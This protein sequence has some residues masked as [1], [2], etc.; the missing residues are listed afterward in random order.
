MDVIL[1]LQGGGSLG[2]YECGVYQTLAPW[3]R[4][5]RHKLSVVC[6][7]SIGAMNASVIAAHHSDRDEGAGALYELW[8]SLKAGSAYFFPPFEDL[9][10]ANAVWTSL[11][12]G[13]PRMFRPTVPF[14]NFMPPVAW[15][16]FSAFYDTTP[17]QETLGRFFKT[18][19][20][21]RGDPRLILT[22]VDLRTE[23]VKVFDSYDTAITPRHV[24]ASCS[25]P[26]TFPA[27]ELNGT[28]YWDG[29][30]WSNTPIRD[31][32]NSIQENP[33]SPGPD[34]CADCLVFLVELFAP[35]KTD[36]GP[37]KGNWD[38]WARRDRII[39]QDK[40]EYDAKVAGVYNAHIDFVRKARRL[41]DAIPASQQLAVKQLAD[42][43][44]G[45]LGKLQQKR[46]LNLKIY[47]IPRYGNAADD[48]GREID[49]SSPR[50]DML[51]E[52][53]RSDS[54]SVINSINLA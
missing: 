21:G 42:H 11:L 13:N 41:L 51:I 8:Q 10:T 38:V 53:G 46:R 36:P 54:E 26:P 4:K 22:A 23:R 40:S 9:E 5:N 45:E 25:L 28:S 49:F 6:G 17:I 33:G 27:T 47:P 14:W 31:A 32:L 29:G 24:L 3:L 20:P 50:I 35:P 52:Q 12:L 39:F 15:A 34:A 7:T 30:L 44:N 1:V 18:L 48:V 16:P 19:G 37:I 2:A 43:I